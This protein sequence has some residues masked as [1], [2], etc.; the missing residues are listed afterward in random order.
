MFDT[1]VIPTDG[2]EQS[3]AV[4][5][6]AERLPGRA[7]RL[8]RVEPEFQ[9]LAP[10]PLA[11]FRP[12][13]REVRTAQIEQELAPF[14]DHPRQQGRDVATLV[15]FGEAADEILAATPGTGLIVMSTRGAGMV[16]RA[17]L[18]SVADRIARQAQVPVLLVRASD[19]LAAS[20]RFARIVVPLDGS[21]RAEQAVPIAAALAREIGI[22]VRLIH[23]VAD[24]AAEGAARDKTSQTLQAQAQ[25]LRDDG[26]DASSE[27]LTGQPASALL[28]ALTPEDLVV[29]TSRGRGG[30]GRLLGSVA[31]RL[32]REAPA[33]VLLA[34]SLA[35]V[36][37]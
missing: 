37:G 7:V 17:L 22:P 2:S 36:A 25:T 23:V 21:P 10:G 4:I 8:V 32:V 5:P 24:D 9:V 14:V 11:D 12:D 31:D 33:P 30:L 3:L 29:M 19:D 28:G 35:E 20:P 16:G 18:G 13:W 6:Y 1:I 27:I 15:R 26:L 34:P